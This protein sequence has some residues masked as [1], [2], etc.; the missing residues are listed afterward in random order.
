MS[1]RTKWGDSAVDGLLAGLVSGLLMMVYLILAGL[2]L[3]D[4]PVEVIG[5]FSP[6]GNGDPLPG[7]IAHLAVSSIYGA[8]F[9]LLLRLVGTRLHPSVFGLLY[10]FLLFLVANY[11]IIPETGSSLSAF[12]PYNFA[13]AHLLYGLVLGR[14]MGQRE[15]ANANA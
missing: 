11:A 12:A 2:A 4:T 10:G 13:M 8:V 9:G 15:T 7:I 1:N 3:G 14:R 5:F 6:S